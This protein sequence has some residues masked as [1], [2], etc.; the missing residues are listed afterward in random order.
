MRTWIPW[1]EPD[2]M[3]VSLGRRLIDMRLPFD[4]D[5]AKRRRDILRRRMVIHPQI[6]VLD[7]GHAGFAT[8][9]GRRQGA[10]D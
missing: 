8:V 10:Q 6:K 4:A 1:Q 7:A 3:G 5:D 2:A 9:V